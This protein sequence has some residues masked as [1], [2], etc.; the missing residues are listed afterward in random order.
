MTSSHIPTP[1]RRLV[2]E[3][4][5]GQCE[6]CLTPA[7]VTLAPHEID[8]I[9]A[10]QHGG[11]TEADNLALACVLCNKLKGPNIAS[12]DP[13]TGQVTA[14]YHPRRDEWGQHFKLEGARLE[15]LTAVGRTTTYLL[16]LN[17]PERVTER[18]LLL[19]IGAIYL[20]G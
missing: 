15:S 12:L 18:K 9:I 3:R 2:V 14:L 10:Q 16:Q 6:Y 4:A 13:L 7:T 8:H 17:Q 19:T 5:H 20:P 11:V 1:L